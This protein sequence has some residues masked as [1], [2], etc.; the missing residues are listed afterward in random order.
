[1]FGLGCRLCRDLLGLHREEIRFESSVL[2]QAVRVGMR[3]T[4][5]H[6]P[7]WILW[8]TFRMECLL[9]F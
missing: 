2:S 9:R 6:L 1:M 7:T 8:L 4:S 5:R 3:V